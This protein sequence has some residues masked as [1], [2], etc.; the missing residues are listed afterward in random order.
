VKR[1]VE[2]DLEKGGTILVEVDEPETAGTAP[3][4]RP[5]EVVEKAKQAFETAFDNIKPA[6]AAITSKLSD[7]SVSPDQLEVEFGIKLSAG[8][9]AFIATAST[10]ANFKVKMTWKRRDT[11]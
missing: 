2:F 4:A 7:I 10:E 3:A 9:G 5:G 1:F 11:D 6:I 8:A